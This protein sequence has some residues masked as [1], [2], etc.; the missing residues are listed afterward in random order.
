MSPRS[1][2]VLPPP[3]IGP[4]RR[5]AVDLAASINLLGTLGKFLGLAALVPTAVALW[6]GEPVWPFLLAGGITSG[7][8]LALERATKG[9]GARVGV[10]E[11]FLVVALTWL[12]AACF[13]ALPY[14]FTGGEQFNRPVDALFEGMSGFTTT[15][16]TVVTDFDAL[17]Q[18]LLMW[19]ALTQWLGGLGIIVLALAV[20]PRLRVGGRQLFEAEL[21]GPEVDQLGVRIRQA[22]QRFWVLYV[23][24]TLAEAAILATF[25]WTGVDDAMTPF[26]AVAHAFTTMPTG[27]F[28][29]Q[30]DSIGAF[31]P[32]TQWVIV[33]FMV[34]A[35][36]NLA[37]LY[38]AFL[39]GR[40]GPLLRDEETRL[41]AVLL[42]LASSVLLIEL[43]TSEIEGSDAPL[44]NGVFQ[45][46]AIMTGTGYATVDF[47]A[48][49]TLA[50][51]TLVLLMFVGG[52]AGSTT[53]SV[54]VIRHLVLGRVLRRELT[55]TLR[56]EVVM[57]I[58]LS[59][60]VVDE[61]TL[62]AIVVFVLL[63]LGLFIAGAG[64]I[65][66]DASLQGPDLLPIDAISAAA[67]TLGNVG[68]A[69]GPAGPMDSYAPFSDLSTMV[70]IALMWLGRLEVLPI[71]VLFT[72]SYW[73]P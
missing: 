47:A 44:R 56:P 66:V 37:L 31:A 5:I 70:M 16:S 19:R 52:S 40:L 53:G 15:G 55:Q 7:V 72:R 68:P 42:V 50:L 8:G 65:A 67:A 26:E 64:V 28:S 25:G 62:R 57:P 60:S 27:G 39:R 71:I 11:G 21:P 34:L 14:L 3:R 46:V 12:L 6:Y 43:V 38:Y 13:G 54:K 41:Y 2:V 17:S 73:R 33:G 63:Y 22:V 24:L 35:G 30:A 61:R 36:M 51:M 29:T 45:A 69:A 4:R 1:E 32:A 58:R 49:P 9:A 18:S 10:R 48:W 59:G 20:L 23:G